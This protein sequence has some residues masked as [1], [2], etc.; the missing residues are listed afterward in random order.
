M[1]GGNG[2]G[3]TLLKKVK[4]MLGAAILVTL[5][6]NATVSNAAE[7][8]VS[9]RQTLT[10]F[11]CSQ[12]IENSAFRADG[13][14]CFQRSYAKRYERIARQV[15]MLRRC[16]DPDLS[17]E[18][19]TAT[20]EFARGISP[21]GEYIEEQVNLVDLFNQQKRSAERGASSTC[22][23]KEKALLAGQKREIRG[24]VQAMKEPGWKNRLYTN[25]GLSV[26]QR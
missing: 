25:L 26:G 20:Q 1:G 18:L 9:E 16:G 14:G 11:L 5:A 2:V 17:R 21:L 4:N 24:F 6:C 23:P 22:T 12:T 13:A 8:G 3:K 7:I 15:D 10:Q 19:D